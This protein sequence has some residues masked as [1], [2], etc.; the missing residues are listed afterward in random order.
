MKNFKLYEYISENLSE[1]QKLLVGS[2][3][4]EEVYSQGNNMVK[5]YKILMLS[6]SFI[7]SAILYKS[8]ITSVLLTDPFYYIRNSHLGISIYIAFISVVVSIPSIFLIDLV[9]SFFTQKIRKEKLTKIIKSCLE[10]E[11]LLD[12]RFSGCFPTYLI[13][14]CMPRFTLL[15]ILLKASLKK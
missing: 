4:A 12:V 11:E 2:K 9:V 15:C 1:D 3:I 5:Y 8:I 13:S 7:I 14:Y 10:K 6:F